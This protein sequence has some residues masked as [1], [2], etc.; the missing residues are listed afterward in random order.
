MIASGPDDPALPLAARIAEK[1]DDRLIVVIPDSGQPP[2]VEP[3]AA[4]LGLP[5]TR[6]S[7]RVAAGL[8]T[9]ALLHVLSD[10]RERLIVM[11]RAAGTRIGVQEASRLTRVRAAPVLAL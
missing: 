6:L 7:F 5:T 10:A 9:N 4:M 11:T 2:A 3:H 1:G 8:D